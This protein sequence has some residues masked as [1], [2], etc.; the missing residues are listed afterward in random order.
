M[1]PGHPGGHGDRCGGSDLLQGNVYGSSRRT[2]GAQETWHRRSLLPV[3]AV[4]NIGLAGVF[5]VL[6]VLST[7]TYSE[8]Q[9]Q[10]ARDRCENHDPKWL[11]ETG[12]EPCDNADRNPG[13]NDCYHNSPDVAPCFS[14]KFHRSAA[15]RARIVK[16]GQGPHGG[17]S[18]AAAGNDAS[19]G[20]W[21][22]CCPGFGSNAAT[23]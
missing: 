10:C 19:R 21:R 1:V 5:C 4:R 18:E 9:A 16:I 22:E 11:V 8:E 3:F 17:C 13:A 15:L 12:N 2:T 23:D 6:G 14:G 7:P 20:S